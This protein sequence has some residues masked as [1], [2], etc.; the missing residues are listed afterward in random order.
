MKD[1]YRGYDIQARARAAKVV[2]TG[3]LHH[4]TTPMRKRTQDEILAEVGGPVSGMNYLQ[5]ARNR[6]VVAQS[7]QHAIGYLRNQLDD[8]TQV[9]SPS[10][11]DID[12]FHH[13]SMVEFGNETSYLDPHISDNGNKTKS[14]WFHPAFERFRERTTCVWVVRVDPHDLNEIAD[15]R[16]AH[17]CLIVANFHDMERVIV[18]RG[19]RFPWSGQTNMLRDVCYD[20][21]LHDLQIFDPLVGSEAKR[22]QI[23][24]RIVDFLGATL[25][26]SGVVYKTDLLNQRVGHPRVSHRWETGFMV[27][28]IAQEYFRRLQIGQ[29]FHRQSGNPG[30]NFWQSVMWADYVSLPG[31]DVVRES[32]MAA[33]AARAIAK[34]EYR[35]RLAIELPGKNAGYKSTKLD[36]TLGP[37]TVVARSEDPEHVIGDNFVAASAARPGVHRISWA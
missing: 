20:R 14:A 2:S 34:S 17:W 26:R 28:A 36:P 31:T 22:N 33:C 13:S 5:I 23:R 27:Y 35:A 30:L 18:P 24:A 21:A 25:I 16:T 9:H 8:P 1:Q 19:Q 7:F 29:Y 32:M 11:N 12:W 6:G 15:E 4:D 37:G 3:E 10:P